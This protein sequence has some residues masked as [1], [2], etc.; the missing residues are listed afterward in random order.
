MGAVTRVQDSPAD[1]KATLGH[2]YRV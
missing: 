1:P 2:W